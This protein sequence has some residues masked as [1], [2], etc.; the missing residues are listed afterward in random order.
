MAQYALRWILMFDAISVA[1]PGART[2]EQARANS[3]AAALPPIPPAQ[4]AELKAIYESDVKPYV[5]Q[6]W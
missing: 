3:E 1:I 5:H 4:M 6:R 2:A